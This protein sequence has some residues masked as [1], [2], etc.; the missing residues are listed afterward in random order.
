MVFPVV[1]YA[2]ESWTIK[3]G[4]RQRT[5]VFEPWC[6]QRLLRVPWTA[7][8]SNQS[9]L[10]EISPEYSFEGLMLEAETPIRWSP[11]VKNRL[12]KKTLMLG[13][14][15]GR[16]RRGWQDETVGWHHWLDGHGFE[17]A[18][19]IG[20]G[21]ESLACC[22]PRSHKELDMTER[23]NWFELKWA[24]NTHTHTHT[25]TYTHKHMKYHGMGTTLM[26]LP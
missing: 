16:G 12:I 15:K 7:R 2:C 6:W 20:D 26:I 3:K 4:E 10:K 9:I 25:Q 13:K 23:L 21:Q 17:Q 5:D 24:A 18:P 22:S 1:M 8:G 14:I 19:G 11:D